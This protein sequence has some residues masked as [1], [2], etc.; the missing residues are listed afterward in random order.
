[1]SKIL[2]LGD[3]HL[4]KSKN[5][6]KA[7][8]NY[9]YNSR[10]IDQKNILDWVLRICEENLVSDIYVTGDI[11]EDPNPQ[12]EIINVFLDWIKS[13]EILNIKI[14]II[15]GNHDYTRINNIYYSPLDILK[16]L[17]L[18]NVNVYYNP[19][20]ILYDSCVGISVFPFNDRKSLFLNSLEESKQYIEQL[21]INEKCKIP[22]YYYSVAIGHFALEGSLYVG[23]EIDDISN[24]I[25][26]PLNYFDKYDYTWMGHVHKYQILKKNPIIAHIGS[27][28]ISNFGESN[29]LK[30]VILFDLQ[31]KKYQTIEIPTRKLNKIKI[32][33]ENENDLDKIKDL[34]NLENSILS[35]ELEYK[36]NVSPFGKDKIKKILEEKNVYLISNISESKEV[37]IKEN[38]KTKD[39]KLNSNIEESVKK[40]SEEFVDN[41]LKDKFI[42]KCN[43]IIKLLE[44]K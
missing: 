42:Y 34:K 18:H 14:H 25:I 29:D 36:N 30:Y 11:F 21:I 37:K 39:F 12:Y 16:T 35:I 38:K 32:S 15:L 44:S 27:M 33:I 4:G 3:V 7:N 22:K 23:D 19:E 17:D 6:G 9:N 28:D 5:L 1:M 8:I 20:T 43:E 40:Y 24:E 41:D 10:L 2:I 26:L 13:L 31:L